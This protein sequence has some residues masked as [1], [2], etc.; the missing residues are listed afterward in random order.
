MSPKN[1]ARVTLEAVP[2]GVM[3]SFIRMYY[4]NMERSNLLN[5]L[6]LKIDNEPLT[7]I[8]DE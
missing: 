8:V 4:F 1:L 5:R 6:L 7:R 2:R 3:M